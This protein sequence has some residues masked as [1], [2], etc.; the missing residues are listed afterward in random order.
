MKNEKGFTL[1]ELIVVIAIMGVILVLALP[2]IGRIQSSNRDRKYEAYEGSIEGAAKLY[3]D[4]HGRD[5]FGNN[6]SGC[7]QIKYSEL[8]NSNLIKDFGSTEITCSDDTETYVEVRKVNDSYRYATAIT[9]KNNTTGEIEYQKTINSEFACVN[10]PDEDV[11]TVT[12]SPGSS[13]WKRPEDLNITVKVADGSGLNRNIGITYYWTDINGNKVSEDY[14]YSYKNKKNVQTVSYKIPAKNIPDTTGQYYLVVGPWSSA[15]TNGIQ[16]VLGNSKASQDQAGIYKIDTTAPSCGTASGS[17]TNWTNQNFTITQYCSDSQSGCKQT[18][19]PKSY[20]TTTKTDTITIEDNA[21]NKT[22]CDVN[23]YLDK[24]KPT[25]GSVIGGS[26]T[27]AP[28]PK[29]ISVGCNDKS[30]G[31]GCSRSRFEQTFNTYGEK[32]YISISDNAGNTTSCEVNKYIKNEPPQCPTLT[33]STPAFTWTNKDITFNFKFASGTTRWEW[34]TDQYGSMYNWGF[35]STSVTSKSISGEGKRKIMVKVYDA[36]GNSRECFADQEYWI[37]KT[38]PAC[39]SI[40]TS[41]PTF[42][43]TNQK[44]NFVFGF[45]SDTTQ[46]E[47]FTDQ[48]GSMYSW[49]TRSTSDIDETISSY[50][51]RRITVRVY[52]AAGNTR[53]CFTDHQYWIDTNPPYAP[54]FLGIRRTGGKAYV[55]SNTCMNVGGNV[56]NVSC[57]IRTSSFDYFFE[58]DRWEQDVDGGSGLSHEEYIWNHDGGGRRCT[59]WTTECGNMVASTPSD[60]ATYIDYRIRLVD[61]AGNIGPYLQINF[62]LG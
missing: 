40:S 43:W 59:S 58:T 26:T 15:N 45:N 21:G 56:Y 49:G 3:I 55:V 54:L 25:C 14:H 47:W 10:E 48:G 31:S 11:P 41:V 18:S 46:W 8:K 51:K 60:R 57:D 39:P 1:V 30:T 24:D 44:V 16:D 7:I 52:D 13:D 12:I 33:T 28:G 37:D 27:W 42:T 19:F 53:D 38:A 5:L 23:V 32:D 62:T 6:D 17:K 29:T 4:S 22:Q 36:A 61:N 34:Y 20:S 35:N 2:Q 50:G 9:C